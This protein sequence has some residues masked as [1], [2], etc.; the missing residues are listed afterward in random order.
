MMALVA[1]LVPVFEGVFKQFGGELPK[2]TQVS[3]LMSEAVTGYWWAMFGSTARRDPRVHQVEENHV[4]AA[5]S[6][7]TSACACR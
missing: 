7:T 1:F 5:S 4:G 6:G 2:L 3:V